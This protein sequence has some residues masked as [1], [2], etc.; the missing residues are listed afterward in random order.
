MEENRIHKRLSPKE[1]DELEKMAYDGVEYSIIANKLKCSYTNVQYWAQKLG[2]KRH[3]HY[4][5]AEKMAAIRKAEEALAG[6]AREYC[7]SVSSICACVT[8]KG[9]YR[10][11]AENK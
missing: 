7:V 3:P 5:N 11:A 9:V 1:V 6:I 10:D 4:T 2:V 8:H